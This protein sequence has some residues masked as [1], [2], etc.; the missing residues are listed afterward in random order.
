VS[1]EQLS[2]GGVD[3]VRG[4]LESEVLGDYGFSTSL[5]LRSPSLGRWLGADASNTYLFSF[6]DAGVV[7]IV[8][9]LPRQ[10]SKSDLS[11]WGLGLRAFSFHGLDADLTWAYPLVWGSRTEPGESRLH[12]L[13]RYSF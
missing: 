7:S 6:F 9:A 12:F 2:I 5:E 3:S 10:A 1:N 8:S 13:M 4:F 11:S